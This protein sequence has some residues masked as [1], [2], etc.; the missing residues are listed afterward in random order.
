MAFIQNFELAAVSAPIGSQFRPISRTSVA[1]IH[2]RSRV[3]LKKII[4]SL[5][6]E[7]ITTSF[8]L[9]DETISG[10]I[11]DT[12]FSSGA[13]KYAFDVSVKLF[14]EYFNLFILYGSL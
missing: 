2:T 8:V 6:P 12:H 9:T 10:H 4:C 3:N 1:K 5:D 7:N 13:M 11:R 14:S